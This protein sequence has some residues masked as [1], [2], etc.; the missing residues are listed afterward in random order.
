M[1]VTIMPS[2]CPSAPYQSYP[3]TIPIVSMHYT[4]RIACTIPIVSMHYTNRIH[5]LYD[6]TW[7]SVVAT[8][9]CLL[10]YTYYMY[11]YYR[12]MR[13]LHVTTYC[14]TYITCIVISV[15]WARCTWLPIVLH[16]LHVL[17]LASYVAAERDYLF[18]ALYIL[19]VLLLASYTAAARDYILY[20][21]YDMYC[22]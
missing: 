16:I 11:C 17:L 19:H 5:A 8:V 21:I 12:H 13:P 7:C 15:I 4:N 10:Y 20:Y 22:Y 6:Q 3:C 18:I 2:P 14:S 1:S 9:V